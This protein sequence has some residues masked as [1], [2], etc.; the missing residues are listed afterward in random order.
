M[1]KRKRSSKRRKVGYGTI[2]RCPRSHRLVDV[3]RDL[4][5]ARQIKKSYPN[6]TYNTKIVRTPQYKVYPYHIAVLKN[7]HYPFKKRR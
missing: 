4:T 6:K 1:K 5:Q 3:A 2:G 7:P